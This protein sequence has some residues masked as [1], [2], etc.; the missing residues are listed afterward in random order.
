[1]AI[2]K[3]FSLVVLAAFLLPQS[4]NQK[5][6]G[7]P[8]TR[9]QAKIDVVSVPNLTPSE[10]AGQY[11]NPSEELGKRVVPMGSESLFLFPDK[12]YIF[13]FVTDIPP[14]TISDKGTWTGEISTEFL[15][16]YQFVRY[17]AAAEI[18]ETDAKRRRW[19]SVR[20]S[21]LAA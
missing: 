14:D 18:D 6:E 20:P 17:V 13:T 11:T 21:L 2:A 3:W 16:R 15:P 19:S 8:L 4:S 12:T 7:A 1:M 9:L 5:K 10:L